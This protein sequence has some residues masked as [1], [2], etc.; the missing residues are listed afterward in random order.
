MHSLSQSSSAL[1]MKNAYPQSACTDGQSSTLTVRGQKACELQS[2]F[3][4]E[5]TVLNS[6]CGGRASAF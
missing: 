5:D 6:L 1:Q 4:E 3:V 2:L